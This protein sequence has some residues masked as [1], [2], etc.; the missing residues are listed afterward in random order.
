MKCIV[1][2]HEEQI[3]TQEKKGTV[4]PVFSH[5]CIV[6]KDYSIPG[7]TRDWAFCLKRMWEISDTEPQ[8]PSPTHIRMEHIVFMVIE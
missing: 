3:I 6:N 7:T 4:L 8:E 5:I 2:V 1:I